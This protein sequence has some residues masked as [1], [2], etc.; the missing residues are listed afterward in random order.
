MSEDQTIPIQKVS[1]NNQI[2]PNLDVPEVKALQREAN[3]S[4]QEDKTSH[5]DLFPTEVIDLPSEG[6]FY[7][8]NNP[9]SSGRLEMREMTAKEEDILTNQNLIK[10]GIVLDTLINEL[11]VTQSQR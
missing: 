7:D 1:Q 11:I 10:K 9:L 5:D 2:N 4:L 6:F 8:S 3:Q